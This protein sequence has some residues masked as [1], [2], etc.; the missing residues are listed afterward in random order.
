MFRTERFRRLSKEGFWIVIGQVLAVAGSLVGVR[1]LTELLAPNVYGELALGLTVAT[2]VN[3][4]IFGPI[5]GGITRFYAP[6]IE[7]GD[8][9]GYL[10]DSKKI[11]IYATSLVL[12]IGIIIVAAINIMGQSKW[13]AVFLSALVFAILSG[14]SA[15]LSGIQSAARHR[16]IVALHQGADTLL[17]ALLSAVLVVLLGA[18]SKVAMIGNVLASAIILSSQFYFFRKRIQIKSSIDAKSN[19]W[20]K[21]IWLFSWPMGF[22]GIFTWLQLSSD[23]WALQIFS[24]IDDVGKYAVLYQLGFV[25][26]SLISGM[27]IQFLLPIMYQRAGDANDIKRNINA[28][29]LSWRLGFLSLIITLLLFGVSILLHP[30]IFQILVAEKFRAISYLFPWMLLAGGFFA[31]AQTLTSNLLSQ[32]KTRS[33]ILVKVVTAVFGLILNVLGAYWYGIN[34]V[35]CG[36]VAFSF[37][38]LIWVVFLVKLEHDKAHSSIL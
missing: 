1:L 10:N 21:Y 26:I 36:G 37:V 27:A 7:Y 4:F 32:M 6:A 9:V 8:L 14:Y 13:V 30:I 28:N 31:T 22:W 15:T 3:Q 33:L 16:S 25:P 12:L 23:R 11:M 34:G 29:K 38:Y 24:S 2:L 19:N 5:G 20:E 18:T 35:V 17:R